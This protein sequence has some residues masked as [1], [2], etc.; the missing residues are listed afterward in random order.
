MN[1]RLPRH[2]QD[3]VPCRIYWKQN[4]AE[5]YFSTEFFTFVCI[6]IFFLFLNYSYLDIKYFY[7]PT[8]LRMSLDWL[9]FNL[10]FK[11]RIIIKWPS[12]VCFYGP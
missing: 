4:K 3:K 7:K 9:H 11:P 12:I 1:T 5:I 8:H 10:C 2:M 6:S